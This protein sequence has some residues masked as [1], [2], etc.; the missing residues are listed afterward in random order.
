[1]TTESCNEKDS[2]TLM[3]TK[4]F[5]YYPNV[6][7]LKVRN[8]DDSL[9]NDFNFGFFFGITTKRGKFNFVGFTL[10]LKKNT[11]SIRSSASPTKEMRLIISELIDKTLENI[12]LLNPSYLL[13]NMFGKKVYPPFYIPKDKR[14]SK[15][16]KSGVKK[17]DILTKKEE[18]LDFHSLL[19]TKTF[20]NRVYHPDEFRAFLVG[21][22]GAKHLA[23]LLLS[24]G[25]VKKIDK[26]DNY[27]KIEFNV[28]DYVG[29]L[30]SVM[31]EWENF[32]RKE[33]GLKKCYVHTWYMD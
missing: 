11:I 8:F 1:M 27:H 32:I 13:V 16:R 2:L 28:D 9:K 30:Y 6:Q 12:D 26:W 7:L 18:I 20:K 29:D 23:D 17:A 31:D 33:I 22:F 5:E 25:I 10:K 15:K 21:G 14:I 24:L 4:V 3:W 19:K